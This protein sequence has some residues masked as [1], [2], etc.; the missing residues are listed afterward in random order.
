MPFDWVL[1]KGSGVTAQVVAKS[2][3]PGERVLNLRFGPGR[4]DYREVTQLIMLVPG[5]Y[6]FQGSYKSDIVSERGLEWQIACASKEQNVLGRG[7]VSRGT[8]AQWQGLEFSF[9][10]PEAGCPAQYVKLVFD[11]RSASERFISGNIWFDDFKIMR[12][13]APKPAAASTEAPANDGGATAATK[14]APDQPAAG[15]SGGSQQTPPSHPGDPADPTPRQEASPQAQ[16]KPLTSPSTAP[17]PTQ[18]SPSASSPPAQPSPLAQP[19]TATPP[20]TPSAVDAAADPTP[21]QVSPQAVP[22]NPTT[23]PPIPPAPLQ[24]APGSEGESGCEVRNLLRASTELDTSATRCAGVAVRQRAVAR[25]M[26]RRGRVILLN[27]FFYPDH[28]PTSELVSDLAFALAE[29]G[30]EV[31]VITSRQRYD[32]AKA[33][34]AKRDDG[35]RRRC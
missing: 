6:Q 29:R 30:F 9:T 19:S 32:A 27:R 22:A 12:E 2:D 4:V 24:T 10:V 35:A 21:I 33:D 8:T 23:P 34:L 5:A 14:A 11:A 1:T 13:Q 26:E 15:A 16:P 31:T 18:T 3:K 25:L 28:S 7:P 20:T 17:A